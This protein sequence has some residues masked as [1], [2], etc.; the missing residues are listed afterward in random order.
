VLKSTWSAFPIPGAIVEGE[1]HLICINRHYLVKA[2]RFGLNRI[3]I[4]DEFTPLTLRN[5][6]KK[7]IIMPI[8]LDE[9]CCAP[10]ATTPPATPPKQ[11]TPE[12]HTNGEQH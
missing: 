12:G 3:E 4:I 1:G 9:K 7:M 8:R 10:Q 6:G 2:L 11:T 5:E